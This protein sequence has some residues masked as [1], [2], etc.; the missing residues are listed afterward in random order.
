MD[1]ETVPK[2]KNIDKMFGEKMAWNESNNLSFKL[3]YLDYLLVFLG[4]SLICNIAMHV[5]INSD[6][7]LKIFSF[8]SFA[9][10]SLLNMMM[11]SLFSLNKSTLL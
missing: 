5:S 11:V 9:I 7:C 10:A 6:L 3:S 2:E 1:I 8:L 4:C